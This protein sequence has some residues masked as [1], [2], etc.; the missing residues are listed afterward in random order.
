MFNNESISKYILSF[1]I[2]IIIFIIDPVDSRI[3]GLPVFPDLYQLWTL[4][5]MS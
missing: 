3:I 5:Q 4:K 1:Y 2:E